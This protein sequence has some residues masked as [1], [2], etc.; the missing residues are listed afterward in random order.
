MKP[1][2]ATPMWEGE[3][4]VVIGGGSSV[5]YQF[6]V[7]GD[8]I[9][10]VMHG[11]RLP[12]AYSPYMESLL[13]DKRVIGVN[14]AFRLGS[15]VDVLLFGDHAW[16]LTWKQ[17]L[18]EWHGLIVTC[19]NAFGHIEEQEAPGIKYLPRD[20]N[21]RWGISDDSSKL[22]WNN[23]SGAAAISLA[24][25]FGVK[26]VVLLGFDMR[27]GEDN[28]SHWHEPHR[29]V[30]GT[31]KKPTPP[32]Q[33]HLMGFPQIAK[34]AEKRGIEIINASPDSAIGVFPKRHVKEIWNGKE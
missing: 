30:E 23:N 24:A 7:P 15:W 4:C 19:A 8:I 25:H 27:L 20:G 29:L 33:R 32:F 3:E 1:W 14:N 31:P 13:K 26:R 21:K 18:F 17:K 2:C 11:K 5:P 10:E 22:A 6:G 9:H 16:Y 12:S 34:D 28:S